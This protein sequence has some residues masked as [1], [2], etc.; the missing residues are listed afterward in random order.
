MKKNIILLQFRE[1]ILVAEHEKECISKCLNGGVNIISKNIFKGKNYLSDKIL[2]ETS[3]IIIGGSGDFGFSKKRKNIKLWKKIKKTMP[4][5]KKAI[6]RDI[7]ILGICL[8]H[9][10]LAYLLGVKIVCD[11]S[12]KEVGTFK[13]FLTKTGKSD[14]LFYD[15][16]SEFLAQQ[17]HEDS[18]KKIPSG[19]I[20]LASGKK[21]K[22]QAFCLGKIYGVQFHPELSKAED[23]KFR[24][25][26]YPNYISGGTKFI[27]KNSPFAKKVLKNFI[28][29]AGPKYFFAF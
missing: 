29:L 10:Y 26:I 27:F 19:A 6:K 4:F 7:P 14:P 25:E 24:A 2:S 22:I 17:G 1:N 5:L 28:N 3:G 16:P 11:E 21:C 18:I 12:Q 23:M 8:G 9:H 13:V 20:L 15:M